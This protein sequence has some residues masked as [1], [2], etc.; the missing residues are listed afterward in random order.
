M[1]KILITLAFIFFY[2]ANAIAITL[3]EA[4]N[5]TYRNNTELNAER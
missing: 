2:S 1:R 4:L 3:Y 5:E